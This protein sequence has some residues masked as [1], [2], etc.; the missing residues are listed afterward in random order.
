[1]QPR[2]IYKIWILYP[3]IILAVLLIATPALADYLGP[4]RTV[5]ATV[6]SCQVVLYECQYVEAKGDYRE[7]RVEDWN[8]S[9]ESKPW[10]AYPS[11]APACNAVNVGYLYW[12]REET[13]QE[14]IVTYPPAT[15]D[16]FLQNCT[17]Q[18]GW[19]GS[20]SPY[21]SL[22][23]VEPVEGHHISLIEGTLNGAIFA[24]PG[25]A[26]SCNVPLNEGNNNFTYWAI[27][28]FGDS[29]IMGT[30]TAQ[31]DT[32]SPDLSLTISGASGTN[33]WYVSSITITAAGS[34]S[35][36][37]LR[38]ALLSVNGEL[39][40]PSAT[41]TDGIYD[42]A[43]IAEDNAGNQSMAS[44][45]ISVDTITPSI[46]VT[47]TG[48][49]SQNHWYRSGVQ[50]SALASDDTSGVTAVEVSLDGGQYQSYTNPLSFSDGR[51]TFQLKATDSAGNVTETTL[52]NL[53]VDTIP[54]DINL[55]ASW[56]VGETIPYALQD[57]GSGLASLRLVIEGEDER[58]DKIV[59]DETVSGASY[60]LD[61]YWDGQLK[62]KTAAPPGAYL[63]WVKAS[64]LA[65]N[66][67]VRL[68]KVIVPEPE[69]PFTPLPMQK[70]EITA[71]EVAVS[72]S[73]LEL[74]L[75]PIEKISTEV[76]VPTPPAELSIA[77]DPVIIA[78]AQE[79][80]FGGSTTTTTEEITTKSLLLTT[81]VAGSMPVAAPNVLWGAA[82]AAAI[83]AATAYALEGQRKR[84]ETAARQAVEVAQ[85]LE[86]DAKK[87]INRL[88][89]QQ[90]NW[91]RQ[92]AENQPE[93]APQ[94]LQPQISQPQ[95]QELPAWFMPQSSPQQRAEDQ[96]AELFRAGMAAYSAARRQEEKETPRAESNWWEKTKA[97]IN[98]E[99]I[100]PVNTYVYKPYVKPA[101][102]S[103]N[104]IETTFN[105]W[106]EKEVRQPHIQPVLEKNKAFIANERAALEEAL[107]HPRVQAIS[108]KVKETAASIVTSANEKIY[109]PHLKPAIEKQL[110]DLSHSVE[111]L[112]TKVYQPYIQPAVTLIH[113]KVYQPYIQPVVDKAEEEL[114]IVSTVLHEEIYQPIFE[115]I[116]KDISQYI[117]QPLVRESKK[118]WDEHG[119]W[120]HGALDAVGFIPG[121]G[122]IA[123]GVNGVIYLVEG[124]KLEAALSIMALIPVVGD[125]GKAGKWTIEL[126]QEI[127]DTVVEKTVKEFAGDA[128]EKAAKS[129]VEE[130][131]QKAL[132]ESSKSLITEQSIRT[133][134]DLVS[135]IPGAATSA[136]T[137]K[138]LI[139]LA[140]GQV[141]E[142]AVS[143]AALI[144]LVGDAASM[145][146]SVI[147][148]SFQRLV[149]KEATEQLLEK[150]AKELLETG[151]DVVTKEIK[152]EL[153][154]KI[155]KEAGEGVA[156]KAAA[157]TLDQTIVSTANHVKKELKED[158][159]IEKITEDDTSSNVTRTEEDIAVDKTLERTP[160]RVDEVEFVNSLRSKY[161]DEMVDRFLPFC[162]R[163]GINP[164]EV[165]TRPPAEGQSLIGWG[166]DIID[167]SN[168]V[169]HPLIQLNLTKAE[170][171]RIMEKSTVRPDSKVIVLGYGSG[172][173]PYFKLSDEIG[174][175]HLS[176]PDEVW[177]PF[178]NAQA[179]FWTDVNAPFIEKGIEERKIFLFNVRPD[180][181]EDPANVRRFSLPE[182]RLL[183]MEKNN[184]VQVP[185]GKYSAFVPVESMDKF[186]ETLPES[187]FEL[188]EQS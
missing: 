130:S 67:S 186:Q 99:I 152:Q 137:V 95:I 146:K 144:P 145:I 16:G 15:V 10:R 60:S 106:F 77:E 7:K 139:S 90:E 81:G 111:V 142:A 25:G 9:N 184:Y 58:Y 83:G 44:K 132:K 13:L 31:V 11:S 112:K 48:T 68:G 173:K 8:C 62:D 71:T 26:A 147:S 178:G 129:L 162:E 73:R 84:E 63:V 21:L 92:Q 149:T 4:S 183:E 76:V 55:P 177:K 169:N 171:K 181:I 75:R 40:Q 74:P 122:E 135:V 85:E 97:F 175:C 119:E 51:Y 28:S 39:W 134:L 117:Y 64:D 138:S 86:R 113:E 161:G 126:G 167:P 70:P 116:V 118:A 42:I 103:L 27:S 180:T 94:I 32:I 79:A 108:A 47:I 185:V 6:S 59:W 80:A 153:A 36:S 2:P 46:S 72:I 160:Q 49:A 165:L 154:E 133:A 93:V 125:M 143:A 136:T 148:S 115:P 78:V 61:F 45:S 163:Y 98:N 35:T 109:Q 82:A 187:L 1:M 151:S 155:A 5:T 3:V 34:D 19:C 170:L 41:L 24:C 100:Q 18:N 33:D 91:L 168:P 156:T 22:S 140:K 159:F 23:A 50:V 157:E 20:T 87:R 114:A 182:L 66:E 69:A 123:D 37:G 65:G 89:E 128:I 107:H 172:E 88:L 188:G 30:S 17:L 56:E 57:I 121:L 127:V 179:N 101:I 104:R 105:S 96:K 43:A 53:Q 120:V 150:G 14:T 52:Q 38:S 54:P 176:L 166:L 102:E 158:L 12:V 174:G 164:Y 124:R 131:A 110:R 29:S 141:I